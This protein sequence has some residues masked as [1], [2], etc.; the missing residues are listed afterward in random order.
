[1]KHCHREHYTYMQ[2]NEHIPIVEHSIKI[3]QGRCRFILNAVPYKIYPRLITQYLFE[4][5]LY[6]I[7]SFPPKHWVYSMMSPATIFQRWKNPYIIRLMIS[8]GYYAIVYTKTRKIWNQWV[9]LLLNCDG[10]MLMEATIVY[11]YIQ[12]I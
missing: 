10:A 6:Q 4:W 2:K 12:V 3:I 8:F 7:N 11:P 5:I 1:M 9:F